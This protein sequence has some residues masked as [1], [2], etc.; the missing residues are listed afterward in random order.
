MA[1]RRPIF[2][3]PLALGTI[4]AGNE[5]AGHPATNLGRQKAIGLT[6]QASSSI[7]ARG[8]MGSA[9]PIDF[10]AVLSA[11]AQAGTTFRLR[12]GDS[13]AEV[14]GSADYDSGAQAFISPSITR[15]D[16]LYHSHWEL[17][18]VQTKR[19]WRLDIGGHTGAFEASLLV[20]GQKIEPAKFYDYD[21]EFSISDT[22]RAEFT[23]TG[24]WDEE[25]GLILRTLDM[26]LNWHD[27]AEWEEKFR[28][29]IERVGTTQP[30][31]L[32]WDPEPTTYRQNRTYYGKF[33]KAPAATGRRKPNTWGGDYKVLSIV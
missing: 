10:C 32:C 8:D 29:L 31:Y 12:L 30:L 14:D 18:S 15:D 7:W 22:G 19:W 13:Q 4:T 9:Y 21:Q 20:L 25:P 2:V 5:A 23:R 27:E 24:V 33:E 1:R 16:G 17:P 11:N 6:W 28:P 26:T 3:R